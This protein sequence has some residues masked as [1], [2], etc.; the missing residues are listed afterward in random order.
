MP[1]DLSSPSQASLLGLP[2]EVRVRIYHHL[3]SS[4]RTEDDTLRYY[5]YG[6]SAQASHP[7][8]P[9]LFAL[10]RVC[11]VIR[12]EVRDTR[13][14]IRDVTFVFYRMTFDDLRHWIGNTELAFVQKLRK[15]EME[16]SRCRVA[17]DLARF[18]QDVAAG[19]HGF[20]LSG[21]SGVCTEVDDIMLDYGYV[22]RF[23]RSDDGIWSADNEVE[24]ILDF[25][26]NFHGLVEPHDTTAD[27]Q[28]DH[29]LTSFEALY[30]E[31]EAIS[32]GHIGGA[33]QV[34]E[35]EDVATTNVT[36]PRASLL[37]RLSTFVCESTSIYLADDRRTVL[38]CTCMEPSI[39]IIEVLP[40]RILSAFSGL[41][42]N[43]EGS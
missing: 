43:F 8:D 18:E 36:Y 28:P 42:P 19:M 4:A 13:P 15:W 20:P 24:V 12:R 16:S 17:L 29:L 5:I 39:R 35:V 23:V 22:R 2:A 31:G 26:N 40:M 27:V 25:T 41:P 33:S 6:S 37:G 3:F 7:R 1:A 9:H 32:P 11:K 30:Y 10:R 14:P 38:T 21:W 34:G